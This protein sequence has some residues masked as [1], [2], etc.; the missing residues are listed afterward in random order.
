M[1]HIAKTLKDL[2]TSDTM[3]RIG[4]RSAPVDDLIEPTLGHWAYDLYSRKPAPALLE[5]GAL[6]PTDLDL[7]CFMSALA[8]RNAVINLPKYERRR[9]KTTREGEVVVSAD[10]RHGRVLSLSANKEVFSFSVRIEDM[11]VMQAATT[12]ES[13]R[14]GA[15][16]NFMLVD[17]DGSWHDGWS[18]IQ[19]MPNRKEND[20]LNDKSLWTGNSVYFK[21]FVHPNRW[22]S[23]YGAPY[24]LTKAL[25]QRLTEECSFYREETKRLLASGIAFPTSGEGTRKE[26]PESVTE[27]GV[28]IKVTA[29]EC[30]VDVP[31][32]HEF[33]PLA[34]T[35][36]ALIQSSRRVTLLTYTLIPQLRFATRATELAYFQAGAKDRSFPSWIRGA[37]WDPDYKVQGKRVVWNRL[38]LHQVHPWTVGYALRYRTKEKTERVA[39]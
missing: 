32:H 1:K 17:L 22:I 23:F 8:D 27:A 21:N 7:A 3:A 24:F 35:Q 9:P 39:Q 2:V 16:R 30:E 26:Y 25:I 18:T 13:D 33:T 31:M 20:F 5:N 38:V 11:N 14:V 37:E 4:N 28:P 6:S 19:F 34:L 36:E 10:N 29:F 15:P 12:T